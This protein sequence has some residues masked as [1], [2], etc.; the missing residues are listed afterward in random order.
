MNLIDSIIDV[1][2]TSLCQDRDIVTPASKLAEDLDMDSMDAIELEMDL[3]DEFSIRLPDG[4]VGRCATV[5]DLLDLVGG[6]L[7]D[8]AGA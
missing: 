1:V 4:S 3:E 7:A 5:Q 6:K 8:K 2:S